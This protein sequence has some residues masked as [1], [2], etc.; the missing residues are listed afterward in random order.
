M[1]TWDIA[2]RTVLDDTSGH[3]DSL[4]ALFE[5]V[6]LFDRQR[7]WIVWAI[8]G[9]RGVELNRANAQLVADLAS[10]QRASGLFVTAADDE[11]EEKD[12]VR[13]EEVDA[14][15]T[16]LQQKGRAFE[17]SP[18]LASAMTLVSERSQ[19]GDLI[20]LAGAQ[21]M[22]EGKRLLDGALGSG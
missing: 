12:R 2:G 7:L 17:F 5:I 9:S 14:V 13:V 19:R 3:P 6:E 21:G 15:R 4:E 10:L 18:G 1:E 11:V 20:V 8:R 16:A 22:N